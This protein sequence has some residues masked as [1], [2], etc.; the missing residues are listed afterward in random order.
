MKKML[1]LMCCLSLL[2][3]AC[4]WTKKTLGL[5]KSVPD[6]TQVETRPALDLPPDFNTLPD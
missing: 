2:L 4:A 6:E 3:S 1:I 5:S